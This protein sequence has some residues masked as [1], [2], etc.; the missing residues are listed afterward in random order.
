MRRW[1]F[2]SLDWYLRNTNQWILLLKVHHKP[3][4]GVL[5]SWS[6]STR[7]T[8]HLTL[9]VFQYQTFNF[10]FQLYLNWSWLSLVLKHDQVQVLLQNLRIKVFCFT[11]RLGG[12]FVEPRLLTFWI[13]YLCLTAAYMFVLY[14]LFVCLSI[15]LSV[16]SIYLFVFVCS[17]LVLLFVCNNFIYWCYFYILMIF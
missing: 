4:S 5:L 12:R 9:V 3:W 7:A 14:C 13:L 10:N 8:E 17:L 1:K 2:L 6:V 15:W 16:L 11:T